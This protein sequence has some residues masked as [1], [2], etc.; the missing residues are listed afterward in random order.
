MASSKSPAVTT[1][2]G[3]NGYERR[4]RHISLQAPQLTQKSVSATVGQ[5]TIC[6]ATN[7]TTIA[8]NINA[9]RMKINIQVCSDI[10]PPNNDGEL[11]TPVLSALTA[12]IT[13]GVENGMLPLNGPV[14]VTLEPVS[15]FVCR[16]AYTRTW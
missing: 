12:H 4:H 10:Q 5:S 11:A 13:A 3:A 14:S 7:A 8:K 16:M 1:L 9:I 15:S 2:I 6:F